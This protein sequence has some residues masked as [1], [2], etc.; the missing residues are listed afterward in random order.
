MLKPRTFWARQVQHDI[1]VLQSSL[2]VFLD[3]QNETSNTLKKLL[4][5]CLLCAGIITG[6][7]Y[8]IQWITA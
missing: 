1:G 7:V 8:L 4:L 5:V 2:T 6:L 3:M